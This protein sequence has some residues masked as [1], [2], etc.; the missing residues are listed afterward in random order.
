MTGN[1]SCCVG[2]AAQKEEVGVLS[3]QLFR[4][5][6][7]P[8]PLRKGLCQDPWGPLR[9]PAPPGRVGRRAFSGAMLKVRSRPSSLPPSSLPLA[10]LARPEE[11]WGKVRK[12]GLELRDDRPAPSPAAPLRRACAAPLVTELG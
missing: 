1:S 2:G 7:Q 3:T 5:G 9:W 12:G 11:V 6:L 4:E 8:G 10:L